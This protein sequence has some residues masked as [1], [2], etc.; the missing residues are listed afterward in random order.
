ML[1]TRR[2]DQPKG[3]MHFVHGTLPDEWEGFC[4]MSGG[5]KEPR[6]EAN[7]QS[8]RFTDKV[9]F[10]GLHGKCFGANFLLSK[11]PIKV[12]F[13]ELSLDQA[14]N[15]GINKL[16]QDISQALLVLVQLNLPDR[17]VLAQRRF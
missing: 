12:G 16:L 9:Y 14:G 2:A 3:A 6:R 8:C 5:C 1:G 13:L 4:R 11:N 7:W 15:L 10:I 17:I